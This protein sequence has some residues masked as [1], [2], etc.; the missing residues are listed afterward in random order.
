MR[1]QGGYTLIE[2][3]IAVAISLMAIGGVSLV[4][5]S[6]AGIYRVSDGRARIAENSRF[7]LGEMTDDLRMAGFMGCFNFDM[8]PSR[9]TNLAKNPADFENAFDT[10]IGGFEASAS[11]W[12]P[13]IDAAVGTGGHAPIA[14]N[15]VLVIRGPIGKSLPLSGTMT[16][17]SAPIP[18]ASVEGLTVNGLAVV[19]DCSFANVFVVTQI[20]A[21]KKVVHAASKN[22]DAKLTKVF[23][24]DSGATVTPIATV[25]YFVAASGDGVAGR[26]SLWRQENAGVA[27]EIAD[28]VESMQLEYGVDTNTPRDQVANS[29]VTADNIGA[30]LVVAVRVSLLLRSHEDKLVLRKQVYNY[31]GTAD[32]T[33]PDRRIYTPY[34]TTIALRNRLN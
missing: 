32:I 23:S 1:S 11:T 29:F 14:G 21:D 17:T 8:F 15:D 25:S 33:A 27:E 9:F 16:T 19:A 22:T 5:I 3:L 34:T 18:L 31:D 24:A 28:G 6:S 20:P 4:L 26:R 13:T 2:L 30:N 10:Q 7:S 12:A